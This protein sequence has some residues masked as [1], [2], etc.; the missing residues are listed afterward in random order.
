MYKEAAKVSQE[1]NMPVIL[2][3]STH[4]CHAKEKVDFSAFN[5]EKFDKTPRFSSEN[6]NYIPITSKVFPMKK[7]AL[8]RLE[9]FKKYSDKSKLN[10]KKSPLTTRQKNNFYNFIRI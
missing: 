5:K 10:K 7:R 8:N 9:D 3:L 2:R 1:K 6:E 4:V